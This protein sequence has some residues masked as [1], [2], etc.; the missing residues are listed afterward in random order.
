MNDK[1]YEAVELSDE[2]LDYVV[3]GIKSI[4]LSDSHKSDYQTCSKNCGGADALICCYH[5]CP[6][7]YFIK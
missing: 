5:E 4:Q 7:K 3:G 2:D 1:R 6:Y